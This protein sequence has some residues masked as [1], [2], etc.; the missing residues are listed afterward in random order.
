MKKVPGRYLTDIPEK[1]RKRPKNHLQ[2]RHL[3]SD[4]I[5]WRRK[6]NKEQEATHNNNQGQ[7]KGSHLEV[8]LGLLGM[9][10]RRQME[11]EEKI[12]IKIE[13]LK[14]KVIIII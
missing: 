7:S 5:V 6:K 13:D 3:K 1:M 12:M 14:T 2:I 4:S 9:Q 11:T 10:K 8:E